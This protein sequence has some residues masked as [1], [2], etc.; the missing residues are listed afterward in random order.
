MSTI[1]PVNFTANPNKSFD[2]FS[3]QVLK[4]AKKGQK[5]NLK[6]FT[7]NLTSFTD[8]FEAN[9]DVMNKKSKK[10][11]EALVGLNKDNMASVVYSFLIKLNRGNLNMIE[12]FA[13]N[14][15]KIAKRL[16]DPVHI[17]A[18]ANDLREVYKITPPKDNRFIT[19]LFEEKRA[20][21]DIVKNYDN[22]KSSN[23][24]LKS[25]DNYK[26]LLADVQYDI[27]IRHQDKNIANQ[28]LSEAKALYEELGLTDKAELIKF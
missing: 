10:F 12:E 15:L 22:I 21:K 28:E 1:T 5:S 3:Q 26:T 2:T 27:G 19:I 20:L 23:K 16:K 11:A 9:K 24:S 8:S 14:A 6:E 25:K 7:H 4:G 13:T 18:R 17:M